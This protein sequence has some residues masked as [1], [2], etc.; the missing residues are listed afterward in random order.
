MVSARASV[1]PMVRSARKRAIGAIERSACMTR[2]SSPPVGAPPPSVRPA[3]QSPASN[4]SPQLLSAG[5]VGLLIRAHR[6]ARGQ[7]G[8]KVKGRHVVVAA[9]ILAVG[10]PSVAVATG[11]GRNMVLGKRN[12]SSGKVTRETEIIAQ[13]GTYSTRQSNFGSGGG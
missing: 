4:P 12:P 3:L 9:L 7:E 1:A 2:G 6:S 13:N 10:I 8:S 5:R 11:E